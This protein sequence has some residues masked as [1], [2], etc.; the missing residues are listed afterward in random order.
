MDVLIV[1]A[2]MSGLMAAQTLRERGHSVQLIERGRS[3]GGRLATRRVGDGGLADHGAQFFTVRS[4]TLQ[5][6]V[7]RWLAQALVYVWGEGW[8]DGSVKRT[9]GDGHARTRRGREY[10]PRL[11][12]VGAVNWRARAG[13]FAGG[14]TDA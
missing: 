12:P 8:S 13:G 7:D 9:A 1:G 10:A 6:Y 11:Q 2:G 5:S 14:L 3:V 4:D